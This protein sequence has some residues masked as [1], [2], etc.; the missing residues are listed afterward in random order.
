[1]EEKLNIRYALRHLFTRNS[2]SHA[3]AHPRPSSAVWQFLTQPN[4]K[5]TGPGPAAP[6]RR[7]HRHSPH[8]LIL[9]TG[10]LPLLLW[11]WDLGVA[12]DLPRV[13]AAASVK[14]AAARA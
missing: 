4:I 8:L 2:L 3:Y 7:M 14:A 11:P 10:P 12:R 1:M 13:D 5:P 6:R 9:A